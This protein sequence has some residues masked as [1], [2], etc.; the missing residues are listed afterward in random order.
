[1]D[2]RTVADVLR[3]PCQ[4]RDEAIAAYRLTRATIAQARRVDIEV[5]ACPCYGGD[6]WRTCPLCSGSGVTT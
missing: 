5:I 1:M 4:H 6:V 2:V 3:D